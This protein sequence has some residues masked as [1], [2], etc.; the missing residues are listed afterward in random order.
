MMASSRTRNYHNCDIIHNIY[1]DNLFKNNKEIKFIS[2]T[3][4]YFIKDK[5]TFGHSM[6]LIDATVK[7]YNMA[8]LKKQLDKAE[9]KLFFMKLMISA[10]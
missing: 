9:I 4:L 5:A 8:R 1:K 10:L 2:T 3:A 7:P 6:D